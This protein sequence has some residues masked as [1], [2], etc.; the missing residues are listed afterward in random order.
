MEKNR[1][2]TGHGWSFQERMRQMEYTLKGYAFDCTLAYAY[3][4]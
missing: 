2:D 3:K 4:K 1:A